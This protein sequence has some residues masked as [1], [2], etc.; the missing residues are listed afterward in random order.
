MA[1]RPASRT[2]PCCALRIIIMCTSTDTRSSWGRM[3]DHSFAIRMD[4]LSWRFPSD[5]RQQ[6]LDGSA[7]A[8]QIRRSRSMPRPSHASGMDYRSPTATSSDTWWL[9]TGSNDTSYVASLGNDSAPTPR[10][11]AVSDTFRSVAAV[12][13]TGHPRGAVRPNISPD[14]RAGDWPRPREC[15]QMGRLA[16]ARLTQLAHLAQL[17]APRAARASRTARAS[18]IARAAHAS[19]ASSRTL[20][21]S[22][23]SCTSRGSRSSRGARTELVLRPRTSSRLMTSSCVGRSAAPAQLAR[24]RRCGEVRR[25][26][27]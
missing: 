10:G 25:A 18:R 23:G 16:L 22:C 26:W 9:P 5:R 27:R 20:H 21:S 4:G 1:G 14:E 19:C 15:A 8:R 2:R 24:R 13:R 7:S 17:S 6:A 12:G 3:V 11:E